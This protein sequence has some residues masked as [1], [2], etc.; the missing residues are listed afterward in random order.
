MKDLA[1]PVDP[2][3]VYDSISPPTRFPAEP[4]RN[5]CTMS[6]AGGSRAAKLTRK[7]VFMLRHIR[8]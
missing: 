6:C 4:L 2:P 3:L 5:T 8:G 1:E 7:L